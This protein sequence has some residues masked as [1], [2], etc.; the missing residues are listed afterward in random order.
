LKKERQAERTTQAGTR[1]RWRVLLPVAMLVLSAF[2]MMLAENQQS[3]LRGMGTG[4]EV[5]ARVVNAVVN[6]PGFYFGGL[7]PLVPATLN[8]HLGFDGDRLFG[9]ALF[10]FLIGLSIDR[11]ASKHG[12]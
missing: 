5:P 7:I 1:T 3:M 9:I 12:S 4:W 2:L 8:R 11:R 10:W 6:G